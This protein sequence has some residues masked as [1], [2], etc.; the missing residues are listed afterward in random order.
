M[1]PDAFWGKDGGLCTLCNQCRAG[2]AAYTAR[3]SERKNPLSKAANAALVQQAGDM[4]KAV[5]TG[6]VAKVAPTLS[7]FKSVAEVVAWAKSQPEFACA[8][9]GNTF[10]LAVVKEW[11]AMQADEGGGGSAK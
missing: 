9:T 3:E 6:A 4:E 5:T 10:V 8:K 2:Y 1:R 11:R 7:K